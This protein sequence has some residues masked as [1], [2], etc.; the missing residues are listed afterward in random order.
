MCAFPHSTPGTGGPISTFSAA[1]PEKPKTEPE[2]E[3]MGKLEG[4]VAVITGGATGIGLASHRGLDCGPMSGFDNAGVDKAF[5]SGTRIQ[6]NFICSIG[7]GDPASVFP[8]NPRLS[9]EEAGRWA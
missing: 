6:S 2:R 9:F 8:R 5:F 3:V 4:K 7:Y 1:F